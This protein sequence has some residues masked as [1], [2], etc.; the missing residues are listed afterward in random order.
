MLNFIK[1]SDFS[2][3]L[4]KEIEIISFIKEGIEILIY[5]KVDKVE[6]DIPISVVDYNEDMVK[7]HL[8]FN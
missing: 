8:S 5:E 1:V 7:I 3:I 2:I 6:D 4:L